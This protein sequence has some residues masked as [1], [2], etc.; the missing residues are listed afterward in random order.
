MVGACTPLKCARA[1]P[2]WCGCVKGHAA[3]G[4]GLREECLACP[5]FCHSLRMVRWLALEKGYETCA[6]MREMVETEPKK[7]DRVYGYV[8]LPA[9]KCVLLPRPIHLGVPYHA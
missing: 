3:F 8:R 1:K 5:P 4:P 6:C 9:C 7:Q 2:M